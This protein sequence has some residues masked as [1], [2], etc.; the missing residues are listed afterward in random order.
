LEELAGALRELHR[1]LIERARRDYERER[2]LLL[3]PG[4]F[5]HLLTTDARFAWLHS[6]SELMV[7]LDVF[8]EADPSPTEEEA[9]AVRAEIERFIVAPKSPATAGV[10]ARQYWPYVSDDPHVAMAHAKVRQLTQGLPEA[11]AVNETDVLHESHRWAET[12]R[13]RR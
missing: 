11:G 3:S 5:L 12:R 1:A 13:H 8:L 6:L 2:H 4:E 9:A 10:F 7:D